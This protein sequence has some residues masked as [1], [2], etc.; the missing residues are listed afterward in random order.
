MKL[1][2]SAETKIIQMLDLIENDVQYSNNIITDL[3][4]YSREIKLELTE[5]NPEAIISESISLVQVPET[6]EISNSTQNSPRI[7]MDIAKMKRVFANFIKN[8]IE[9]MP[10]GGKLAI[11]SQ[12]SSNE[13]EFKFVDSGI[14]MTKEV[15]DKIW[16]PFF[17]TKA[18]GMGLGLAI[19]RRLIDAHQGKVSVKSIVGQGTTFTITLP[20][21]IK[22]RIDE[23]EKT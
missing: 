18:K 3:M 16:T 22:P 8:A 9:A 1:G 14:G 20:I 12:T 13:V 11:L 15:L 10:H 2:S 4:E 5:T 21:E 17:T 19:C 7:K 23:G 6:V